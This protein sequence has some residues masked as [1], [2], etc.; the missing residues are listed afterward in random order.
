[1][2]LEGL[3]KVKKKTMNSSGIEP[4]TFRH[5]ALTLSSSGGRS[6]GIVHSRTQATE[7]SFFSTVSQPTTLPCA[8]LSWRT[9]PKPLRVLL[10]GATL[11]TRRVFA[12][13]FLVTSTLCAV[14]S[15]GKHSAV[16]ILLYLS[17]LCLVT[18]TVSFQW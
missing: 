1:V 14:S 16:S 5:V 9:R 6:V 4:A 11:R 18:G 10:T 2:Q 12:V 17:S 15:P 3:G 8:P 7:F 13:R